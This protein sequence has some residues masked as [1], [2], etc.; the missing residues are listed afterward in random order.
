MEVKFDKQVAGGNEDSSQTNLE[1]YQF[2]RLI[3]KSSCIFNVQKC[4]RLGKRV[5][6]QWRRNGKETEE[7]SKII[8]LGYSIFQ[9]PY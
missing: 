9:V 8:N 2:E 4:R 1:K 7:L 6:D 3:I 5:F